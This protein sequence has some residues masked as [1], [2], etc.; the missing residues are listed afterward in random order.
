MLMEYIYI[1]FTGEKVT[2]YINKYN[3]LY[4]FRKYVII[5][6]LFDLFFQLL[7]ETK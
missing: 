2:V 1:F 4:L 6:Q 7:L 5:L 3:I